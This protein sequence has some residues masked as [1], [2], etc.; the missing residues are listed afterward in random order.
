MPNWIQRAA[1]SSARDSTRL[2]LIIL[3]LIGRFIRVCWKLGNKAKQRI[4]V[5]VFSS[6]VIPLHYSFLL[7]ADLERQKRLPALK[8]QVSPGSVANDCENDELL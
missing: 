2:A 8:P 5:S 7:Q 3:V 4:K 1:S 6:S